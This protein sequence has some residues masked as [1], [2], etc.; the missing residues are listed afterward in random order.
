MR[1]DRRGD[2]EAG[3]GEQGHD[4]QVVAEQ[5][6]RRDGCLPLPHPGGDTSLRHGSALRDFTETLVAATRFH[7]IPCGRSLSQFIAE[8]QSDPDLLAMFREQFQ[9]AEEGRRRGCGSVVWRGEIAP[10]WTPTWALT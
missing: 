10:N 7:K 6:P 4:L 1:G 2:R 8:G 9:P 3:R 5:E